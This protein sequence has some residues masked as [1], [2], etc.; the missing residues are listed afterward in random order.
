MTDRSTDA[1]AS[2]RTSSTPWDSSWP[3][4]V[5]DPGRSSVL[6]YFEDRFGIGLGTFDGFLLLERPQ[7]YWLLTH[8]PHVQKLKRLRVH[9]IGIPLLRKMKQHLKPTTTAIQIFGP[10]ATRNVLDLDRHQL[11]LVLGQ[12]EI[13]MCLP[14]TVGYVI[15][16]YHQHVIGC[17]LYTGR[18]LLSQIPQSL[19]ASPPKL[20][21]GEFSE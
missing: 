9:N 15:L 8:S 6:G 17:G 1:G 10:R 11:A 13:S 3:G 4:F 5:G 7:A 2:T 20:T 12:K 21:S 14:P 18:K 19:F 16:T